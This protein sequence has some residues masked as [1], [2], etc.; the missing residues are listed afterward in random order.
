MRTP[1]FLSYS[2]Q[3]C[4][5]KDREEYVLRYLVDTKIPRAPQEYPASIGSAFDAKVK[6]FLHKRLVGD[7]NPKYEFE[8]LFESQVESQNR[9]WAMDNVDHVYASYETS[10]MLDDL[11]ELMEKST[12]EP[13]FE[14]DVYGDVRGVPVL[15]KPDCVF[16]VG[17]LWFVLDWKVNGYCSKRG[18]SPTKGFR[19]CKDGWVGD[20]QSKTH[21]K[22]HGMYSI[23]L[24]SRFGVAEHYMEDCGQ[25]GV[26]WAEQ[27]S[28]YGWSL[29][30]PIGDENV[31]LMIDQ[32]TCK[33]IP[34]AKP[35]IRVSNYRC[36]VRDSFQELLASRLQECWERIQKPETV[37]DSKD[38]AE[39][40][41]TLNEYAAS[42][43]GSQDEDSE[44]FNTITRRGY[45]G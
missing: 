6:S 22:P 33:P 30:L 26:K 37:F 41:Q 38:S 34:E 2:A 1:K 7:G 16:K 45:R 8:S 39:Q 20:K 10:G 17:T 42:M 25:D 28:M 36:R 43:H 13:R 9:D 12:V 18:I 44:Y 40:F 24:D 35:A 14:F 23:D 29:G 3:A 11:L 5:W 27:L 31:V 32:L 21:G 19:L 4:F 15:G